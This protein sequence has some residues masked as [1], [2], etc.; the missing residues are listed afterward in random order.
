MPSKDGKLMGRST[1]VVIQIRDVFLAMEREGQDVQTESD[2][3]V[4]TND[5]IPADQVVH[6]ATPVQIHNTPTL[7]AIPDHEL[8]EEV[9]AEEQQDE[10]S[11]EEAELLFM[12]FVGLIE[13]VVEEDADSEG[14]ATAV[15]QY[16]AQVVA[17]MNDL[18]FGTQQCYICTDDVCYSKVLQ[19]GCEEH[20]ICH[21]CIAD[22]FEQAIQQES[23]Y[24]PRC[25]DMTGPLKIEDFAHLLA[26]AH[27]DLT[28]RYD[29]KLQEY[30]MDKRF[31]R[32]CGSDD[33]KTFLSPDGY[34]RDEEHNFTTADCPTCKR[35]TCVF[36]TK[37]VFKATPHEC[38]STIAKLNE[39]YSP[40]ARFK[41]CPFCERPGLLD[42]GC[43]HVTC[44]C[45]EEWCFVCIRKWNGGYNHEDC[46]QYNV[47]INLL[48]CSC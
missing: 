13:E 11:P 48:P 12:R 17:D 7:D 28:A 9:S 37:I 45:G 31:R 2:T 44:E 25:C 47:C 41:Y 24:P 34:E 15:D 36:C 40:E 35:T 3:H 30:H 8:G 32:Y 33:C 4:N 16:D 20:W 21:D 14:S 43:N 22:P 5:T 39:D 6:D 42:E 19:L 46:G 26:I 29:A 10:L 38:K 27:P 1:D 18:Q 23:C